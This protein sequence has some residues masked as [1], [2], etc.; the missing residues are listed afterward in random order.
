MNVLEA[1][2]ERDGMRRMVEDGIKLKILVEKEN[3]GR[4]RR[5]KNENGRKKRNK[6]ENGRK[7]MK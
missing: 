1:A 2:I 6:N 4:R 7:K 5:N 3:V